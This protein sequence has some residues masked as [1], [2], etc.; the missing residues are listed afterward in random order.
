MRVYLNITID[1]SGAR[2]KNSTVHPPLGKNRGR[3]S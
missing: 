3:A 1:F 2:Q